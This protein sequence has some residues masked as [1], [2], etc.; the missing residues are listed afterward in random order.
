MSHQLIDVVERRAF[1]GRQRDIAVEAEED[2]VVGCGG[3]DPLQ[4][5]R[6][7]GRFLCLH[8]QHALPDRVRRATGNHHAVTR[9]HL[10][11]VHQREHRLGILRV[12]QCREPFGLNRFAPSH[13]DRGIVGS[14]ED[15]PRFC[16]AVGTAEMTACEFPCGVHMD[17]Q[18]LPGI[19]Q[20]HQHA[21]VAGLTVVTPEPADRI[22]SHRVTQQRAVGERCGTEIRFAEPGDGGADPF[23]G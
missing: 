17:R 5:D 22:V 13:P 7:V 3:V 10:D 23:L 6:L 16:L 12:D 18:S 8:Q 9:P 1:D 14:L 15:V 2:L 21:G 11:P 4:Q 20:L 19:E